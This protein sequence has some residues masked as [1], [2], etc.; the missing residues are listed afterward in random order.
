M[1]ELLESHRN[2]VGRACLAS[3][4]VDLWIS[5]SCSVY[6]VVLRFVFFFYWVQAG[7]SL[8]ELLGGYWHRLAPHTPSPGQ[9]H[10]PATELTVVLAAMG[11]LKELWIWS[12]NSEWGALLWSQHAEMHVGR[13]W[14]SSGVP[15]ISP[16]Q[17]GGL[18]ACSL[19]VLLLNYALVSFLRC[20]M[21]LLHGQGGQVTSNAVDACSWCHTSDKLA[22]GEVWVT[23]IIRTDCSVLNIFFCLSPLN[24]ARCQK[25]SKSL[26]KHHLCVHT[27]VSGCICA[28]TKNCFCR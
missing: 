13:V 15:G 19:A 2:G 24:L 23:W 5:S 26:L 7:H 8:G 4:K 18:W 3:V 12:V 16:Q 6:G 1:T 17:A 22:K 27:P 9:S 10:S 20:L 25:C 11:K 21:L 28:T 14:S